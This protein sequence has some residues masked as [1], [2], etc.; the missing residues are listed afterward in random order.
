MNPYPMV[1]DL[2]AQKI[3]L[4]DTK[5]LPWKKICH[6]RS[7]LVSP[8]SPASLIIKDLNNVFALLKVSHLEIYKPQQVQD[9]WRAESL[10]TGIESEFVDGE[11]VI[12]RIHPGSSAD[13]KGLRFGDI[14]KAVNDESP[15][16]WEA[17]T[18]AGRFLIERKNKAEVFDIETSAVKRRDDIDLSQLNASTALLR[19]PSF[20]ASYFSEEKMLELAKNISGVQKIVVDLRGNQGGNFVAGLRFL[21]LFVCSS[22]EVGRLLRPRFQ[23]QAVSEMINELD[24][25][26]QLAI[27]NSSHQVI[28]KTFSNDT[29]FRGEVR[30]LVD[31]KTSSVA[32]MTAQA[33]KEL[34]QALL[35]GS[36]SQGQ[37]LV[38]VWYPLNEVSAGAEISIP[39]AVYVSQKQH[40]IEGQGVE[41]DKVLYYDL[42]QMQSGLDS[43]VQKALD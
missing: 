35:L 26:T 22:K 12:F 21:S 6:S 9:I 8:S 20:R 34:R 31:H 7:V 15:N 13:Q 36:S 10:E 37:L 14:I 17:R 43:W 33:L 27:L 40:R 16:P 25:K 41:L 3:F 2:V 39:E 24:D 19:V 5:I 42:R 23:Y 29:C 11:L 1:C 4:D 38:G 28:L 30:V 18:T 32:E